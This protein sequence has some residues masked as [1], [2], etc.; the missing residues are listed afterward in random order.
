MAKVQSQ[1]NS[2]NEAIELKRF[3]ENATLREKRDI[4]RRTLEDKLP[5]IFETNEETCPSFSF[6]DQG[7]YR[8]GTGIKPLDSDF[9]IDQGMYFVTGTDTFPDPVLLKKRV[10]QALKDHTKDVRIRTS[11]VTVFYQRDEEAI[12]HVDIAI[13]V[14]GSA[15][16]DGK[17]RLAKGRESSIDE[18][19]FW[20]LSDPQALADSILNWY[21]SENDRAQFRRIVRYMKRWR[22]ENFKSG[23]NSV[24]VGIGLTV[25]VLKELTPTYS[26]PFTGTPDDLSALRTLVKSILSRFSPHWNAE[27]GIFYHRIVV[28]LPIEPWNDLFANMTDRQMITFKENL[29]SLRDSLDFAATAVA[30]E[31]ACTRLRSQFGSDFPIPDPVDTARK[32]ISPAIVSSSESA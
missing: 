12:Y 5:A 27:E 24:P 30:P 1:F 13:Y 21:S 22:D 3:E 20:E 25:A 4:I 2:F 32:H 14:D 31:D 11:C 15:E 23:G 8:M 26:D 18:N 6:L 7:S 9:D 16:S 29:E 28:E 17:S 10:Y 19:R